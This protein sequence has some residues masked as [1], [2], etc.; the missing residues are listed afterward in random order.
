MTIRTKDWLKGK[1]LAEQDTMFLNV[2]AK[3]DNYKVP[4][5]LSEA[6]VTSVRT[7]CRTF[8]EAYTGVMQSR[9]TGRQRDE[10]FDE[11]LNG[12]DK[13]QAAPAPPVF[14]QISIP[15]DAK[16]ALYLTFRDKMDFFKANE[17][18]TEAD[19][20][21]L[22]ITAPKSDA[23]NVSEAAPELRISL[24]ADGE[25]SVSYTKGPFSGLELQWRPAGETEWRLADKSSE[26]TIVF[27]PQS[28]TPNAPF[29][30][31]LRAVYLLKN[32]RTG[33]WSPVYTTTIG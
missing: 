25:V 29:K 8:H 33:Q 6:W 24:N 3:I 30:I 9:A 7:L 10:W 13:G 17:A 19:G 16:T 20:D 26:K 23:G 27:R 2:E 21:D 5:N 22:M 28:P 32:Q 18:Y 31:E 15:D 12:R 14:T 11:L 1:S 4:Y